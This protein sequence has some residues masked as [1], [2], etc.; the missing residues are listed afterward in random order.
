MVI[1]GFMNVPHKA[2]QWLRIATHYGA[3]HPAKD[4]LM[5][6]RHAILRPFQQYF[7]HIKTMGG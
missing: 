2:L 4:G 7:S 6:K 5:D 3:S 1:D